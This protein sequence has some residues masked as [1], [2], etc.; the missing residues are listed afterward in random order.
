MASK[1]WLRCLAEPL[2]TKTQTNA[3]T[4]FQS[5]L[6]PLLQSCADGQH[7]LRE[8]IAA[9]AASCLNHGFGGFWDFAEKLLLL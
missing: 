7:D 1:S 5:I 8:T 2:N 9:L 3:H 6:L 4:L